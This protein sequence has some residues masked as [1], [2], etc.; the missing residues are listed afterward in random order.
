MAVKL[1][2]TPCRKTNF[3]LTEGQL[4]ILLLLREGTRVLGEG[5]L[6]AFCT[7]TAS[8]FVEMMSYHFASSGTVCGLLSRLHGISVL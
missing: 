6:I 5:F 8:V 4:H 1:S 7:K 3:Y 2:R